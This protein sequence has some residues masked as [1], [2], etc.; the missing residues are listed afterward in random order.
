MRP[1]ARL[2][3]VLRS[4]P[5][6]HVHAFRPD[7]LDPDNLRCWCGAHPFPEYPMTDTPDIPVEQQITDAQAIYEHAAD[8]FEQASGAAQRALGVYRVAR[9]ADPAAQST[10]E[11]RHAWVEA[12]HD[13]ADARGVMEQAADEVAA[14]RRQTATY[15]VTEEADRA[16]Q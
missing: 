12:E 9:S 5:R 4:E 2:R 6:R 13:L 7:W 16:S 11:A 8:L 14:L 15:A 3:R 10:D 1:P